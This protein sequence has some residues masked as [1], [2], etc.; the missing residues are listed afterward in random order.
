MKV[1]TFNIRCKDDQGGNSIA[2]RA[3]RLK[4]ILDKYDADIIGFQEVTEKWMPLPLTLNPRATTPTV[5][6]AFACG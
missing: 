3:P 6:A 4:T 2:E 1:I 5:I